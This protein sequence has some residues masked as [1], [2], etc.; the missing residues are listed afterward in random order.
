MTSILSPD[1][2]KRTLRWSKRLF[3]PLALCFLALFAWN[4]RE[5]LVEQFRQAELGYFALGVLLWAALN[6]IAPL[7][8]LVLFRGLGQSMAYG[9]ALRIHTAR[10][11]AK[12][13]PGGIWHTVARAADYHGAG[14]SPRHISSCLVLEN[15]IALCVALMV[16]GGIVGMHLDRA[17][18][19]WLLAWG[20]VGVGVVV[21]GLLPWLV[22]R[23]LLAEGERVAWSAV[24]WSLLFIVLFWGVAAL[25]FV[26]Y[27]SAFVG[28]FA[29]TSPLAVA[30]VYLFSWA[31]GYVAL[32]APQGI[33]VSEVVAASLL[34]GGMAIGGIA[35]ALAGFR[36]VVL[37]ADLTSWMVVRLLGSR[38]G[39][40]AS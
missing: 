4:A 34:G 8:T 29:E 35:A 13:L 17:S 26:S 28:L 25:A 38:R 23:L 31:V 40:G 11:P 1:R 24:G 10:L 32:F 21:V 7:F 6:F 3:T 36:V 20:A 12:Y 19:W 5:L 37:I 27:T 15:L 18:G 39:G 33:G 9:D 30:G 2:L 16:G 14:L 22:G